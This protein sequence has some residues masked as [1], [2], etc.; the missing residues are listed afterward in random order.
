MLSA[1]EIAFGLAGAW[2]LAHF[3]AGGMAYFD[4]TVEGFWRSFRVAVLVAPAFA[5]LVYFHLLDTP[6]TAGPARIVLVEGIAY[7]IGWVAFPLAVF[8]L[9]RFID[10]DAEVIGFV[11]AYNW[12]TILQMAVFLP[13]AALGAGGVAN[14]LGVAA[15][16]AI[17]AYEWFIARTALRLG[18]VGAAGVVAVDIALG[19]LISAVA[20]RM[21]A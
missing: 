19:V 1:R 15:T 16:L 13:V 14:L 20:D 6:A 3:D 10:R 9:A 8:H 4:R 12:S 17:L 5:L 11:V 7:V 21:I 18:G 2:R